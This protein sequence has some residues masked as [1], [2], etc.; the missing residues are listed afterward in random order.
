M[1][2]GLT[3]ASDTLFGKTPTTGE[4]AKKAGEFKSEYLKEGLRLSDKD[5]I[6]LATKQLTPGSIRTYGPS[7]ALAGA[8]AYGLGAFDDPE[9][10]DEAARKRRRDVLQRLRHRHAKTPSSKAI[11][12]VMW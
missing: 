4:L 7:L 6:A 11:Q 1:D 8:A 12:V 2:K 10:L 5:A 3:T 9:D